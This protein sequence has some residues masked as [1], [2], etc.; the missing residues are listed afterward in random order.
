MCE[1]ERVQSLTHCQ[2]IIRRFIP[3]ATQQTLCLMLGYTGEETRKCQ[4]HDTPMEE[5]DLS[6]K[7]TEIKL[8]CGGISGLIGRRLA[9]VVTWERKVSKAGVEARH[10]NH[11]TYSQGGT[12]EGRK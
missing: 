9:N 2:L 11:C 5:R 3:P 6:S 4:S 10:S 1:S 8:M 7:Q 12:N